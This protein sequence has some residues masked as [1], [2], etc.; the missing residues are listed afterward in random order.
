MKMLNVIYWTRV[1]SES[2]ND[3]LGDDDYSGI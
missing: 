1:N 2:S 3:K